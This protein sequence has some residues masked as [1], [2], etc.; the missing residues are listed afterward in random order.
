MPPQDVLV[1]V[2][3]IPPSLARLTRGD[4][5]GFRATASSGLRQINFMLILG[6]CLAVLAE[7]IVRLLY[8]RGVRA[9]PD[10]GGRRRARGLRSG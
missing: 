7:P 2:A 6:G 10:A 5:T 4:L 9:R 3:T 8:E 1:A